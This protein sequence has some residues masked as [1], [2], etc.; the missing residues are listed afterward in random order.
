MKRVKLEDLTMKQVHR[1]CSTYPCWK[2]PLMEHCHR[3]LIFKGAP[4]TWYMKNIEVE[5]D[6]EVLYE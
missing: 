6:K 2:C 3:C 5:V 4:Y 1:I